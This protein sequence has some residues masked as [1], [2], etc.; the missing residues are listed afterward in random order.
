M[1]ACRAWSGCSGSPAC[2]TTSPARRSFRC[3]R[4]SWS[5]WA[6][7]CSTSA[8]S[9]AARTR[10]PACSRSPR[11]GCPIAGRAGCWSPVATRFQ[12]SRAPA[13]RWRC[14]PG[15]CWR[16]GSSTAPAR[17]FR[18]GPRD[19]LIADS[20]APSQ[21]GRAFGL[22]R[23]LDHLGAALGRSSPALCSRW[24]SSCATVFLVAAAIGMMAP[25]VLF[26][27]LREHS[28]AADR[29]GPVDT[30]PRAA[31]CA[32]DSALPGRL[33]A[34]RARQLVG[35][36]PAVR[37]HE[38]GWGTTALPLLWAFHHLVKSL[39]AL[40]GGALSD[41]HSRAV[42]VSFGWAAYALTYVGFGFAIAAL[43][44]RRP[45][46]RLRALPRPRRGRRARDHRRPVRTRRARPRVRPLPRPDRPGGA[47]GEHRHRADLGASSAP[48]GR[49][50]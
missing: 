15:T 43:A 30:R 11:A 6:R 4:C 41:R 13:S 34:L 12:R 36:V 35:R 8:S 5:R 2:S 22:N 3:C 28:E 31:R 29:S 39:A 38:V 10:W 18:S 16:R 24:A 19:A 48:C 26:F 23:S 20:V 44:D 47:A 50:A 32:T 9:R 40:P 25:I 17:G 45:V 14:R 21:R 33:R 7:R 42:V 27:R 37:A 1:R 46:P 49:W